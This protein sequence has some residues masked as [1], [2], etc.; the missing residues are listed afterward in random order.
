[1]FLLDIPN[2]LPTLW[3]SNGLT[4]IFLWIHCEGSTHNVPTL[5]HLHQVQASLWKST[6]VPPTQHQSPKGNV[7]SM[8]TPCT[9]VAMVLFMPFFKNRLWCLFFTGLGQSCGMWSYLLLSSD[10]PEWHYIW[11]LSCAKMGEGCRSTY[12]KPHGWCWQLS[13]LH[14]QG[15]NHNW[16]KRLT[17]LQLVANMID[18]DIKF[19]QAFNLQHN[20]LDLKDMDLLPTWSIGSQNYSA[21][22]VTHKKQIKALNLDIQHVCPT[23]SVTHFWVPMRYINSLI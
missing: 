22:Q 18:S 14:W 6:G 5:Y 19:I 15:C 11:G 21:Y 9:L 7:Y 1:M 4:N 13:L 17:T 16:Y 23:T 12:I 2:N 10:S 20:F 3:I 8:N